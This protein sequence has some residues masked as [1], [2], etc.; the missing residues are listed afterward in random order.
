MF[1]RYL[2]KIEKWLIWGSLIGIVILL[3]HLFP[4]IFFTFVLSY[5]GNTGVRYATRHFPHRR[6][7]LSGLYVLLLLGLLGVGLLVVPRIFSEGRSLARHYIALEDERDAEIARAVVQREA[8]LAPVSEDDSTLIHR[9]VRKFVDTAILRM[10]GSDALRS[11]RGSDSYEL[12]LLRIEGAVADFVPRI[13][14]GVRDFV[15]HFFAVTFQFLLSIIFSFL[16]LWDLPRLRDSARSFAEGKTAEIYAEIA[17]S[18]VAFGVMLGRAFEAQTVIAIVNAVLTTTGFFILGIPSI[19]LLG[20]IVFFCSY[21]PVFGV[22]LSTLP[23]ALLALKVGGIA[24]VGWL[25][26]LILIV[27]AVEAYG[28][29]P[30]IYGH[31]L[32]L[33]PVVVLIILLV[34][35][36]LFG[37]W[38]LLLGV[39]ISAFFLRYVI[40]GEP[41]VLRE[42]PRDER[43]VDAQPADVQL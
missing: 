31:H 12:L 38:G 6:I 17:P 18:I 23:A 14:V 28:L 15:N 40:R 37:V 25:V 20:T 7:V 16:I 29:N 5:I 30:L 10:L 21:I 39:P 4:V 8:A 26:L 34:G 35:E 32:K 1:D 33:H 13:V 3:R 43:V 41:P 2:V 42:K 9:E 22:V 19:A 27:H 11:F 24:Q 36:H